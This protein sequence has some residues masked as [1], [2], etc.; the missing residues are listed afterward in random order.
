[1]ANKASGF[2]LKIIVVLAILAGGGFVLVYALRPV[3]QVAIVKRGKAVNAKP[4]S[5]IVQAEREAD[6]KC[7][8]GGRILSSELH[9]G[10]QMKEGEFLVQLD[11]RALKLDI[12]K[13]ESDADTQ[14]KR[15]AVGSPLDSQIKTARE[16][17]EVRERNSKLG[18][19][20]EIEVVKQRREVTQLEQK[21]ELEKIEDQ[22][23]LDGLKNALAAQRLQLQRMT[24][25]APFDGV[26]SLVLANKDDIIAPNTPIAHLISTS[27]IVE[28]KISEEDFAEI[29]VG[30]SASVR[31]LTYGE[32]TF[33][34][35]VVKI[36]PTADP[37]TQRYIV[38]LKVDIPP[39]KLV[40]GIT[41]EMS[42]DVGEHE[43]TLIVPRR[44]L[45]GHNVLVVNA[46]NRVEMRKV[47]VGYASLNEVEILSGVAQGERV[48]VE[49]FDRYRPGDF[50][51]CEEEK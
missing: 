50:V 43:K 28:G 14:A 2:W 35:T 34:S 45:Y 10:K 11:T 3:A 9:L 48:I 33:H 13:T 1:M 31:F 7:E 12:E 39:E 27:R 24:L 22:Q 41:G 16:E 47:D 18:S 30:Q 20:S 42:I 6:L 15:I 49:Q 8:Y 46:G 44:A 40:P 26:V 51:R 5:V 32:A 29:K 21:R 17:L 4:G 36:L 38:H 19:L 37:A 23:K 25:N